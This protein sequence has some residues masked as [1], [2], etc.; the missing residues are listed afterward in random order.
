M[1][2]SKNYLQLTLAW[3]SFFCFF[4]LA[5]LELAGCATAGKNALPQGG[6]MTMADIYKQETG[7]SSLNDP[8]LNTN[9]SDKDLANARNIVL[10]LKQPIYTG[11]TSISVNQIKNLFKPLSNPEVGLYVFP[12]LVFLE[13]E[14]QPVPGYTT[15]F[16]LYQENHFAIPED[17]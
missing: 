15:A 5:C 8:M 3:I 13:D 7:L 1:K 9:P 4:S 6:D 16:F 11:Y 12:H 10:A 2:I 17:G 14:A